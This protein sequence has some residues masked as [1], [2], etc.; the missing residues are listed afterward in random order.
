M[1]GTNR[2]FD[3]P[4]DAFGVILSGGLHGAGVGVTF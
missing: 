4:L 1:T 2:L 3:A